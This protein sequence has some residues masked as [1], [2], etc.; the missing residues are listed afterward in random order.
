[1]DIDPDAIDSAHQSAALNPRAGGIDWLIGDF[2]EQG[3]EASS[4]GPWD[5]ILANLTGGMLI[6]SAARIRELLAPAGVLVCSGFDESERARV[7]QALALPLR[8]AFVEDTWVG[9]VLS[10]VLSH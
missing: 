6:S 8:T 4:R 10:Q 9:L 3:C 2:R 7:E 1:V 5:L